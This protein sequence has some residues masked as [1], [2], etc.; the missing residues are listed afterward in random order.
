MKKLVH[1]SLSSWHTLI[2]KRW[3][4]MATISPLTMWPPLCGAFSKT[5]PF[6]IWICLTPSS[7]RRTVCLWHQSKHSDCK[8]RKLSIRQC[9]ITG[10]G[11]KQ[12]AMALAHN[13]SLTELQISENSI[14]DKGAAA[15]MLRHNTMLRVLKLKRC[16]ITS[17]G[18]VQLATA[19]SGTPH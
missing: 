10:E 17:E 1:L 7:Q 9:G 3:G 4:F 11:A 8:L 13:H 15:F 14:E 12:L 5:A 18:A 19:L 6:N 16:K 2:W